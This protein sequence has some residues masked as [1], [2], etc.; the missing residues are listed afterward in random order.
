[1][2]KIMIEYSPHY[3]MT[4]L[5]FWVHHHV[6]AEA[7]IY[8]TEFEPKL[9][10]PVPGKGFPMLTVRILEMDIFFASIEEIDHFLDIMGQKNM[11]TSM[12]LSEKRSPTAGPNQHWLS[13]FPPNLKSWSKRQ[14][15]V[16]AV[17]KG[18][19]KFLALYGIKDD[20]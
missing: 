16:T 20:G 11:P 10:D 19:K 3:I 5:S 6:D 13:R 1:M 18:R 14:R 15:I 8:A 7:W 4:P 12:Q 2:A 9:P 17:K